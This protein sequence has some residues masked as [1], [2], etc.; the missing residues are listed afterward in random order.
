M[1]R[2]DR[3]VCA[4]PSSRKTPAAK[5]IRGGISDSWHLL[6]NSPELCVSIIPPKLTRKTEAILDAAVVVV[7]VITP[8][9][10]VSVVDFGVA[11]TVKQNH[12]RDHAVALLY[13]V[14]IALFSNAD[15]RAFVI[16]FFFKYRFSSKS[17]I[18]CCHLSGFTQ[19]LK[20]CSEGKG[21][22]IS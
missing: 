14:T 17:Q 13:D 5:T 8:F 21:V 19:F 1:M 22:P 10:V 12:E 16:M 4:W 9:V 18:Y 6:R 11:V 3:K 7:S 2:K 20:P 15:N